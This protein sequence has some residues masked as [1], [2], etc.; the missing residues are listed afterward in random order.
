[1]RRYLPGLAVGGGGIGLVL[2]GVTA[3]PAYSQQ[4]GTLTT[5]TI[6]TGLEW[7]DNYN[8]DVNSPGSVY[9]WDT[10]LAA[11]IERRTTAEYFR[12][13]AQGTI[14]ASGQ[15]LNG[16]NVQAD[17]PIL[18]F[19][20]DRTVDDS[21]LNFGARYQR[22]DL[23]FFDPLADIDPNGNF[24]NTSGPGTRESIRANFGL[25]LN[26]QGP[27]SLNL[28]GNIFQVNYFDTD[29][30][31]QNANDQVNGSV[32]ADVG[33]ELTP[34]L[35]ALVGG[36]Y[37]Q[38][39]FRNATD[40]ERRTTSAD[41][42]MVAQLNQ[43]LDTTLRL[44]YSEVVTDRTTGVDTQ[45]GVVGSW[46]IVATQQNGQIG[47]NVSATLDEN[48]ERYNAG[49]FKS[50]NWVNASL[51]AAIG[52]TSSQNTEVRP[53]ANIAYAYDL[54]RTTLTFAF[55]QFATVDDNGD[56]TLNSYLNAGVRHSITPVSALSL[57]L[58]AGLVRY[59]NTLRQDYNRA[60]FTAIYTYSLTQDWALDVGYRGRL[61]DNQGAGDA[62]SNAVFV[63]LQ[64][65]FASI[66]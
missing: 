7:N 53:T 42:G 43:R 15:Q 47:A 11:G 29:N 20:Y 46:N 61:K 63:G 64:R 14:R 50:I 41:V 1:M 38:Q 32:L 9:I 51:D 5:A 26:T 33:F 56:D 60:N 4:S 45:E 19:A 57:I 39:Q 23:D 66:R 48:G 40:T 58:G 52:A 3:Y 17:N 65:D 30:T 18:S 21:A 35:Q 2:L 31:T 22:A 54:P 62:E 8:L 13:D 24:A 59:E 12:A 55:R 6:I 44:G 25:D 36:A 27:V 34:T 49:V 37:N 10:V 16:E 28:L